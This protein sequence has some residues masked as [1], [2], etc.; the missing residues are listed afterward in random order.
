MNDAQLDIYIYMYI[1]PLLLTGG[2]GI[3][4]LNTLIVDQVQT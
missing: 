3:C 4:V 2:R 1:E